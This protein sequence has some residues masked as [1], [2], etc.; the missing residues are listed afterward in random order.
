MRAI[1]CCLL[2]YYDIKKVFRMHLLQEEYLF[3][4]LF[5]TV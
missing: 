1:Q 4:C 5:L 2:F 3:Y